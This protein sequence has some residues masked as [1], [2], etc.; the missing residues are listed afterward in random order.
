MKSCSKI[1]IPSKPAAAMA[2]SF[3]VRLPD[4]DTVAI[5]VFMGVSWS[6]DAEAR[7]PQIAARGKMG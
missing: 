2:V 4:K 1:S 6:E 5:E 7:T 3:S